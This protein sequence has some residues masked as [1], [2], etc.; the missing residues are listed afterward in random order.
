MADS[1]P[2]SSAS[3]LWRSLVTAM[4]EDAQS[5]QDAKC[6]LCQQTNRFGDIVKCRGADCTKRAHLSCVFSSYGGV[7]S[8]NGKLFAECKQHFKVPTY[9]ICK[10]P[11][12]GH[13]PMLACGSCSEWFHFT[14]L[15]LKVNS[16]GNKQ[17]TCEKCETLLQSN[18]TS[19]QAKL[20]EN[21]RINILKEV[22]DA[23]ITEAKGPIG[24]LVDLSTQLCDLMDS[25][26]NPETPKEERY[27]IQ[28]VK[29]GLDLLKEF[30]EK[31]AENE[32]E[33]GVWK[34]CRR[35]TLK[36]T[37]RWEATLSECLDSYEE[38]ESAA[39]ELSRE[40]NGFLRTEDLTGDQVDG[41]RGLRLK[42]LESLFAKKSLTDELVKTDALLKAKVR[43]TKSP[44]TEM[45]EDIFNSVMALQ[46]VHKVLR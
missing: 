5:E 27:S 43:N 14:C 9:C 15:G 8:E 12:D 25:L 38:W 6:F 39:V 41:E 2:T 35:S 42:E 1:E 29:E 18:T 13:T 24:D 36:V 4:G 3:E 31:A 23:S 16:F 26:H 46:C 32:S 33:N 30:H 44:S 45:F 19:N 17:Y 37:Q 34:L 40:L 21:K 28:E 22:R 7:V 11:Y 10:R 20:A